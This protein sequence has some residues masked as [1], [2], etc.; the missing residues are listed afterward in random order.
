MDK[1][2]QFKR[3]LLNKF[4]DPRISECDYAEVGDY[5]YA[6]A[7]GE[8]FGVTHNNLYKIL[9]IGPDLVFI[10]KDNGSK[11]WFSIEYFSSSETL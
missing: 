1:L 5:V 9:E 4:D 8:E 6:K 7:K 10:E 3:V 11:E 2:T